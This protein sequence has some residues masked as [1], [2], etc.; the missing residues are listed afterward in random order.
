[1]A[2]EK[3]SKSSSS[4]QESGVSVIDCDVHPYHVADEIIEYLPD[5]LREQMG[6]ALPHGTL[7]N[8]HDGFRGD[9]VP[10]D[11]GIPGSD[12]NLL[13]KDVV[14]DAGTTYPILNAAGVLLLVASP[15]ADYAHELACAFNDWLVDKWL[16]YDNQFIGALA[17]SLQR[18]EKAAEEIH[19][20]GDHPQIRQV[21]TGSATEAPLGREFYWPIYEAAVE[22]DLPVAVHPGSV[23]N[24]ICPPGS[25]AGH[26][27]TFF[28]GHVTAGNHYTS[29]LI[30][31][32]GNGAFAEYPNLDFVFLEGGFGWAATMMW[33]MDHYW[34]TLKP[35]V[36][37]LKKPP[38]EYVRENCYF[39]T[40]PI[41]EPDDWDHLLQVFEMMHAEETLLYCSDYPHWDNDDR[42]YGLPPLDEPLRSRILYKNAQELYDLPDDPADLR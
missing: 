40:Q 35:E 12:P 10:E 34:E 14:E 9:A 39:G 17:V 3:A 6:F 11:G 5:D 24:G 41:P 36:P 29:Q 16:D 42:D 15:K 8:P 27:S 25:G 7:S 28:E 1:M 33:R 26:P 18:P 21:I 2:T 23:G 38:S 31:L 22:H 13:Y 20:L 4:E 37:Y 19:R 30:S 32:V